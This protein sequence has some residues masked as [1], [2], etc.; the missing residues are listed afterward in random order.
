MNANPFR[1]R[2]RVTSRSGFSPVSSRF[3]VSSLRGLPRSARKKAG[4]KRA[5]LLALLA[6]LTSGASAQ[7]SATDYPDVTVR[8]IKAYDETRTSK[9]VTSKSTR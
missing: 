2:P 8:E 6:P 5:L 9:T 4:L 3:A 1:L 7:P